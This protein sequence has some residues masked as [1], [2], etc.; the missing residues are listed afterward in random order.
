[1]FYTDDI[2]SETDLFVLYRKD[3]INEC[4]NKN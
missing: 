4:E 3:Y 1:M 2:L